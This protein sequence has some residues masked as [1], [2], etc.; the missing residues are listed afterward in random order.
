[1]TAAAE[2][3]TSDE[4]AAHPGPG[5]RPPAWAVLAEALVQRRPVSARYHGRQRLLCPHALGWKNGRARVLAYQAGGTTSHGG[6]PADP[7]QRWRSL[8]IDEIDHPALTDGEW[9]TADNYTSASNCIDELE[10]DVNTPS[11]SYH[12]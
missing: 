5:N 9:Q 8:F 1:M 2:T 6:L 12:Q 3:M 10:I 7:R 4:R 11:R